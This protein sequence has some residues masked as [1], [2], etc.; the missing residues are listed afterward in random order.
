MTEIVLL[1]D[2][3]WKILQGHSFSS[4]VY[5]VGVTKNCEQFLTIFAYTFKLL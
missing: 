5:L 2:N 3:V 4:L 1:K